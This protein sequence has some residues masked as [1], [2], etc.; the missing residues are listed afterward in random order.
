MVRKVEM[1]YLTSDPTESH[2]ELLLIKL[3]MI[4]KPGGRQNVSDE[5]SINMLP[6]TCAIIIKIMNLMLLYLK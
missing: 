4:G 5:S 3:Q 6:Q 2:L 1:F